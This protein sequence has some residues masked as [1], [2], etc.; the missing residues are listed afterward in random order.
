MYG[1][2][3]GQ[4]ANQVEI[5][6]RAYNGVTGNRG[7]GNGNVASGD[8]WRY[9]GRGLVQL[10]GRANYDDFSRRHKEVWNESVDFLEAP[11]LLETARYA[12]RSAVGFWLREK[13]Y[14]IADA[15]SSSVQV[16]AITEV[17]N[18]YTNSYPNRVSNFN[19]IYHAQKIFSEVD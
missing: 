6:N 10:T 5:A 13:L 9:K 12:V 14:E 16:N 15:G 19:R 4:S 8:G 7:L 2:K 1:R 11:E 18:R 3:S 17:I